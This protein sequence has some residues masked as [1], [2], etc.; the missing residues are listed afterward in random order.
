MSKTNPV[1]A[2]ILALESALI[3]RRHR[4]GRVHG[5]DRFAKI[6]SN[7]KR[8]G[9]IEKLNINGNGGRYL[10]LD[11]RS[12]NDTCKNLKVTAAPSFVM[13]EEIEF[14]SFLQNHV[15][16]DADEKSDASGEGRPVNGSK[17]KPESK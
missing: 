1:M 17:I 13:W 9:F 2:K 4:K 8:V 14:L 5:T 15:A 11:G 12:W 6:M 7:L 16:T 10:I 3:S